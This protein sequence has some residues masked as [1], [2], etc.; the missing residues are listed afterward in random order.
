MNDPDDEDQIWLYF[1][2]FTRGAS[3]GFGAAY[4]LF[5]ALGFLG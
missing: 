4:F 1:F 3:A 5:L 2:A